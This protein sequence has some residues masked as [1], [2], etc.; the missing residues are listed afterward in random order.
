[1]IYVAKE[2]TGFGIFYNDSFVYQCLY[3]V[4]YDIVGCDYNPIYRVTG[5]NRHVTSL[6]VVDGSLLIGQSNGELYRSSPTKNNERALITKLDDGITGL[7]Y[8][9]SD[10]SL[11]V[12]SASGKLFRCRGKK[13]SCYGVY[14]HESFLFGGLTALHV[15]FEAVWIGTKS[16]RL[17]RC[18]LSRAK[19]DL[20][21]GEFQEL[22]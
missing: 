19:H 14:E 6:A 10:R 5:T 12:A 17:L 13:F 20:R 9:G 11:Y 2:N 3:S 7:A 22:G 4:G 18:P 1:M 16:G 8:D 15:A 21:C